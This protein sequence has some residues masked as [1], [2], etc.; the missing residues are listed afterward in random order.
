M[1]NEYNINWINQLAFKSIHTNKIQP[2]EYNCKKIHSESHKLNQS[3]TCNT[4]TI[5]LEKHGQS[6]TFNTFIITNWS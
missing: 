4:Y 6:Y 5:S 1:Q 3:I 2:Y